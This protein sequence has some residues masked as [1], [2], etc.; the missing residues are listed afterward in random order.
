MVKRFYV[1][2]G[3]VMLLAT[4]VI[5]ADVHAQVSD[6]IISSYELASGDV[7]RISVFGE[8]D[9]SFESIRLNDS[10]SFSY[11]FLGE[12]T[13]R[14]LTAAQ[15]ENRIREGLLGD[16]LI[17][18][19]VTVSVLEYRQ[20]FISGEVRNSGGYAFQPGLTVR[21]AIALAGGLTDRA[22][23]RRITIIRDNDP[24][25]RPEQA[26]LET[27]VRPGDSINIDQGF[28]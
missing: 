19:R 28:F 3:L 22:S 6:Q 9:L 10:G 26:T 4:S 11:P 25:K 1:L 5:K 15:L 24:S 7:I 13:A 8:A 21:R 14:G 23:Q 2:I 12:V 20:F 17:D 27:L 16:Y 18:P